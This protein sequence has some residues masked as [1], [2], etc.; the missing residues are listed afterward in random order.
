MRREEG[1]KVGGLAHPT[2]SRSHLLTFFLL[3]LLYGV[4]SAS[5]SSWQVPAAVLKF[6]IEADP[7]QPQ[8]PGIDISG[9]DNSKVSWS[10][11][12]YRIDGKTYKRSVA[13]TCPGQAVYAC[14]DEF[15]RFV[16]LIGVREDAGE[17]ASIVFEVFA[18]TR[19]LYSSPPLTKYSTPIGI[20]VRIP[21]KTKELRLVTSGSSSEGHHWAGWVNAGFPA[22]DDNPRVGYVTLPVPGFDPSKYEVVVFSANGSRIAATRLG[23]LEDGKVDQLFFAGQGWSTYYAYWVPKDKYEPEPREW[24]PNGGLVL[25]TRRVDKSRQRACEDWPGLVKT[26]NEAGGTPTHDSAL[27]T[28]GQSVGRSLVTGI[29][30]GHPVHP[31]LITADDEAAPARSGAADQNSLALYRYTGFFEANRAGE[32]VFA[33][34]SNWGSHLLVDDKLL[35]SWPGNHDY[36]EGIKGQKQ[37]KVTLQ[38]GIHKLDYFN[39]SPWGTM[40][41]LAAWQ[42]PGGKL[43]VMTGSDFPSTRGYVVTGVEY[44]PAAEKK[45]CF[46]WNVV[47]DWRLDHDRIGLIR[48]RF[49]VI[50]ERGTEDRG[51]KADDRGQK[52]EDRKQTMESPAALRPPSSVLRDPSSA[53]R[54]PSSDYHWVFDDGMVKTGRTVERV[55]FSSGRHTVKVQILKSGQ[56]L[57]ETVQSV[58]VGALMDKLWVDPR[59]PKA[60]TQEIARIDF[61]KAPIQDVTRLYALGKDMPEPA[62][63]STALPVLLERVAELMAQPQYQPLCLELGQHLSSAAVQ[64]YDQALSLYTKLQ[65]KTREGT[66]LRQQTMVLAGE[67]SLRC[68]GKPDAALRLLNQARWEKAPDRT[69]TIRLGLARVETLLAVGDRKEL[70]AQMRQLQ[71]LKG[72]QDPRRQEVRRAGLLDQAALLARVKDDPVQLDNAMDNLETILREEPDRVLSP[73]LNLVRLD[74]HIARGE[75]RIARH[76]AE[77][78]AKLDMAPYDRAQVLV[79]HVKALCAM[80]DTSTA[81]KVLEELTQTYPNS[82]QAAQAKAMVVEAAT[83]TRTR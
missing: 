11:A 83:K 2:F 29:H 66:P 31:R 9:Q 30:H 6:T 63:R 20:D 22:R 49:R 35:V 71:E 37:G 25:E 59:D 28:P 15:R 17:S 58:Y 75:Y 76:L 34:A 50:P 38:P 18:S 23:A 51:R 32:Y 64:Q 40:F 52:A 62:W 44:N 45:L 65:E 70:D 79:R 8:T 74:V 12:Y 19:K 24:L 43:G 13:M 41:T 67:L 56:V 81:K 36:R 55:F 60:L 80:G 54:P 5:S 1:K 42:P 4:A 21:P 77:R 57:A 68:L 47:D 27:G 26:W 33:T 7:N 3:P 46:E 48:M 61:R 14:K 10:G 39:Y 69:W 82:E 72:K 16:A 78:L 73:G 53:V